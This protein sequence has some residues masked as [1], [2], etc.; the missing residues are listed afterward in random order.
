MLC[1]LYIEVLLV[2]SDRADR[3]WQAW[4]L[5]L[6]TDAEAAREWAEIAEGISAQHR[7]SG[8][9]FVPAPR[10]PPTPR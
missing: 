6:I 1:T 8:S 2:D 7:A 3:V 5:E 4:N 9:A 10:K